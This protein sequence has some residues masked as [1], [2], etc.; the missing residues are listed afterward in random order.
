MCFSL[1]CNYYEITIINVR[2]LFIE[3]Y[4]NDQKIKENNVAPTNDYVLPPTE[5]KDNFNKRER[6]ELRSKNN[7]VQ[8]IKNVIY[9]HIETQKG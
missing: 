3:T 6:Q 5:N 1:N 9:Q 8:M 7:H 4:F 2:N